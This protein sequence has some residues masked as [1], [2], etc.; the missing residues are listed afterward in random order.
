MLINSYQCPSGALPKKKKIK[1]FQAGLSSLTS[2][3]NTFVFFK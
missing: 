1:K 2:L 3:M